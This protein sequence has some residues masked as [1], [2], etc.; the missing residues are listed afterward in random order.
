M[1]VVYRAE[2][3]DRAGNVLRQ[4]ALK[5]VLPDF[6]ADAD[7]AA[8]FAREIRVAI[9]LRSPHT[10]RVYDLGTDEDGK[11][12]YVMELVDGPTLKEVLFHHG[13]L[14]VARAVR[15]VG[16]V[17]DAL[18]EAHS[19]SQPVIH[20]DLKPAN[21]FVEQRQGRDWTKIGDFGIAKI[22][23]DHSSGLS[24]TGMSPGT[25]RYMSPEQWTGQKKVDARADL[26]A[27][28]IILYELLAGT[29]PFTGENG[30]QALMAQHLHSPPPPLP[31]SIPAGIQAVVHKLL[32]K[33]AAD[34]PPDALQVLQALEAAVAG[35][36]AQRTVTLLFQK[37]SAARA[38][39]DEGSTG[40][41]KAR[42]G[43]I[44]LS[45]LREA[46]THII[47]LDD[48]SVSRTRVDQGLLDEIC[49]EMKR[50]A[51]LAAAGR[52][53]GVQAD[54]G[55]AMGDTN[56]VLDD[57]QANGR[58]LFSQ[59]LTDLA[60]ERL[61]N[62]APCDLHLRLDDQL[63]QVPWELGFD[64]MDFVATKFRVGREILTRR[65]PG[66]AQ[67][68]LPG[69]T[70]HLLLIADPTETLPFATEEV[71]HLCVLLDTL[72]PVGTQE[73][74]IAAKGL[75]GRGVKKGELLKRLGNADIVHFAGHS[76]FD[77]HN[78]RES[79]WLLHDGA[80]LTASEISK[81]DHA[82]FLVF[83]NSCEAGTTSVRQEQ[84][85][86]EGEAHGLGSAFWQA[87]VRNFIGTFWPIY[88]NESLDFA[89]T[90]YQN[91]ITGGTLGAALLEARQSTKATHGNS[92][93]WGSYMLYGDPADSLFL[94][95]GSAINTGRAKERQALQG[96]FAAAQSSVERLQLKKDIEAFLAR[97]PDEGEM[98]A[99]LNDINQAIMRDRRAS[100][101][102]AQ[103]KNFRQRLLAGGAL[104]ELRELQYDVESFV[105]K[106]DL[107]AGKMLLDDIKRAIANAQPPSPAPVSP[108]PP[109]PA[110]A[111]PPRKRVSLWIGSALSVLLPMLFK[112]A[113]SAFIDHWIGGSVGVLSLVLVGVFLWQPPLPV[114]PPPPPIVDPIVTA[115]VPEILPTEVIDPPP[116]IAVMD[117]DSKVGGS[118]D[119][120]RSAADV[121]FNK[122]ARTGKFILVER[123][124]ID[125]LLREQAFAHSGAVD[126]GSSARLGELFGA[127]FIVT[128]S[129]ENMGG[130]CRKTFGGYGITTETCSGSAGAS[131]KVIDAT[132]GAV[133]YSDRKSASGSSQGDN[134]APAAKV[135]TRPLLDKALQN[136]A[137]G[138][139]PPLEKA[140]SANRP[141][142]AKVDIP[143]NSDPP[144][145]DVK[146][147]GQFLGNTPMIL[148]VRE[149]VHRLS[150]SL[151]GY[152][153]W[154]Q[155]YFKA[156]AGVT[157]T[158]KLAK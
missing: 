11:P 101:Q 145:A 82:P 119:L 61:T 28:G 35:A 149:G 80:L 39:S 129:I 106:S 74:K 22:L 121:I 23:G 34:R 94:Q 25:P 8:R 15:I 6:A 29:P 137:A 71:E 96:H 126:S 13:P 20:R 143:I 103:L 135:A 107:T 87:G 132:N 72:R 144:G 84:M 128:G 141:V 85:R 134:Y 40:S 49:A 60:R 90:F 155:Q 5:T 120:T 56:R 122:L 9:Q 4:V 91:L 138:A 30:W 42:A 59:L 31:D 48:G 12:Y 33:D 105:A 21:I 115:P 54:T 64:R 154:E 158:A 27:V 114:P 152:Q 147:N 70:L 109:A 102:A 79:G 100:E 89:K 131:I 10:V 38:T 36:D 68:S 19:L 51:L 76:V 32:A 130:G 97:Y 73:R 123:D 16:Q 52:T 1:G 142:R 124:K 46:D 92:L 146:L 153:P 116:R 18:A 148:R 7:F 93:T 24:H 139:I 44:S 117:F 110:P 118:S 75:G 17:C 112:K 3:L 151:Q 136:L 58:L 53:R 99:T 157:I 86:Y 37:D 108:L 50:I 88:D 77:A 69:D 2:H 57:L 62:A 81:L 140:V 83:S 104:R 113:F 63:L 66:R 133:L 55:A 111:S 150:L 156:V 98:R 127:E 41:R 43:A 47:T 45:I 125:T 26:Y 67:A 95:D 14:P 65:Q 78:P